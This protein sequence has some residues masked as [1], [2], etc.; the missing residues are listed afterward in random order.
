MASRSRQSDFCVIYEVLGCF[1][2]LAWDENNPGSPYIG[3]FRYPSGLHR[4]AGITSTARLFQPA[5]SRAHPVSGFDGC[6]FSSLFAYR[7]TC[8]TRNCFGEP[9][10]PIVL[11][12]LGQS[13]VR[14]RQWSAG[15]LAKAADGNGCSSTWRP[16]SLG[17]V[18]RS[19]RPRVC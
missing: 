16:K 13:F 17:V 7:L 1:K 2:F 8:L 9:E 3:G 12:R 14:D 19:L 4:V 18:C 5:V 11:S 6:I 15:S 10:Q